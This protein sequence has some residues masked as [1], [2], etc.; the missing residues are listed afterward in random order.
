MLLQQFISKTLKDII[1]GIT[2]AQ[3]YASE[4]GAEIN[5]TIES[6]NA[7]N[8]RILYNYSQGLVVSEIEFDVAVTTSDEKK[9]Q[10]GISVFAGAINLG[11][12]GQS[13]AQNTSVSRI[14]F[15]IPIQFPK[16]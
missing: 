6:P 4:K 9:T 12:R 13:E 16:G 14:K 15:S 8:K 5:P 3:K 2:D 10:G 11:S 7:D 1:D